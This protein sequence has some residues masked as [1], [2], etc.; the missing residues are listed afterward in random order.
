MIREIRG[1]NPLNLLFVLAVL[2]VVG[3]SCG[4]AGQKMCVGEVTVDGLTFQGKDRD[5]TQAR[6]NTCSKYC[7]E[8]DK[9]FDRMYREWLRSPEAKKASGTDKW[10]AMALDKKLGEYTRQCEDDCIKKHNDGSQKIAVKC[11]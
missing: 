2:V 10:S 7:I 3:L 8:G 6:K 5:E 9:G 1:A 11:E 4:P